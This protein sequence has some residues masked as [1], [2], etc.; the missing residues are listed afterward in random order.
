MRQAR[1]RL[2]GQWHELGRF[3]Q[4]ARDG[5]RHDAALLR[6]GAPLDQ[7]FEIELLAREP[8][9]RVLADGAEL[10]LVDVTKQTL[11][12]IGI[13]D[14]TP[15]TPFKLAYQFARSRITGP[16]SPLPGLLAGLGN[17]PREG[18]KGRNHD[19]HDSEYR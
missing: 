10:L 7:H 5:L 12:E 6:L 3:A 2:E 1:D 18:R 8:L 14:P 17:D 19:N 13:A 4:K 9:Q 11:F 15:H 16:G